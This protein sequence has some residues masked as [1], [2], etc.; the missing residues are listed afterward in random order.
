MATGTDDVLA[1]MRRSHDRLSARV[2]LLDEEDLRRPSG[3]A[4][5]TVARVLSHLGSGSQ[6]AQA[7]LQVALGG[8]DDRGPD[9]NQGIWARWDA[10]T[11]E[12][13]A[14]GFVRA[15]RDLVEGYEALT[16]QE[17]ADIRFRL[18]FFAEPVDLATSAGLRLVELALHS[19]D[20]DVAFDSAATIPADLAGIA[21]DRIGTIL[22]RIG[23]PEA[24]AG[25]SVR[26]R[27]DTVAPQTSRGLVIDGTVRFDTVPDEPDGV[28]AMPAEALLRL[29][30][31]RLSAGPHT[32]AG[33]TIGGPITLDELRGVFGGY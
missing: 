12:D 28:V 27:L 25:R 4:Q 33:V 10:M 32:P 31:G 29:L 30:G 7:N 24:V 21:V 17:R 1:A 13:Q 14:A 11:P 23:K 5:W 2:R 16:P 8:A 18:G 20:I 6:I 22:G 3:A 15:S 9:F 26:L 19:W